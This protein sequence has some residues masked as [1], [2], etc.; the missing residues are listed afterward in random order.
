MKNKITYEESSKFYLEA[1]DDALTN[2]VCEMHE[3]GAIME[4]IAEATSEELSWEIE[5]EFEKAW[6]NIVEDEKLPLVRIRFMQ[7][8][9]TYYPQFAADA[10]SYVDDLT[11]DYWEEK[12]L[13]GY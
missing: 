11:Q 10:I 3:G 13:G 2:F 8:W 5:K 1:L 12:L 6:D 4:T 9:I 7:W